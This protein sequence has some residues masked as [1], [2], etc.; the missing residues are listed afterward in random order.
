VPQGGAH[1][2]ALH[3][4]RGPV[5]AVRAGGAEAMPSVRASGDEEETCGRDVAEPISR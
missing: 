4:P 2:A 3:V 1:P 5:R